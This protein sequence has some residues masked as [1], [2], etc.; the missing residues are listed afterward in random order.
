MHFAW[1]EF[2][3]GTLKGP[4]PLKNFKEFSFYLTK[5]PTLHSLYQ[6]VISLIKNKDISTFSVFAM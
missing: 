3:G 2:F 6:S 4:V 1:W 5:R